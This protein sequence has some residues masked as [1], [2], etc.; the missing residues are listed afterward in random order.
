MLYLNRLCTVI[1]VYARALTFYFF[2]PSFFIIVIIGTNFILLVIGYNRES[3]TVVCLG[4]LVF[5]RGDLCVPM[6]SGS[7]EVHRWDASWWWRR[8]SS[9]NS[10]SATREL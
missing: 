9:R 3:C 5:I 8:G 7:L 6:P 4:N 10:K 1:C 2:H